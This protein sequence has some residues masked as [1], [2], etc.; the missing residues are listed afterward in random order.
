MPCFDGGPSLDCL[1]DNPAP[2]SSQ[3]LQATSAPGAQHH[4]SVSRQWAEQGAAVGRAGSCRGSWD[5]SG[6]ILLALV[7]PTSPSPQLSLILEGQT[8][9]D[10]LSAATSR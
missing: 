6:C 8:A 2:H 9:H 10:W 1:L 4:I 3:N 5:P 7:P